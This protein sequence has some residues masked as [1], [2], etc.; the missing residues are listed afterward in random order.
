[1]TKQ[2]QIMKSATFLLFAADFQGANFAPTVTA[3]IELHVCGWEHGC[4]AIDWHVVHRLDGPEA[5]YY[6]GSVAAHSRMGRGADSAEPAAVISERD[7][8]EWQE[9]TRP[10]SNLTNLYHPCVYLSWFEWHLG[11]RRCFNIR[12]EIRDPAALP[13]SLRPPPLS[14]M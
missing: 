12:D 1:M 4:R 10:Q 9:A 5:L 3:L 2:S 14:A 8:G 11:L 6:S 7:S 13:S